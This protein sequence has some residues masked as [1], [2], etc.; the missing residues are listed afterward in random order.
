MR[1]KVAEE[2]IYLYMGKIDV[3]IQTNMVLSTILYSS[4]IRMIE[5]YHP[6]VGSTF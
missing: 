5:M 3:K 6:E 4:T 2:D 1:R